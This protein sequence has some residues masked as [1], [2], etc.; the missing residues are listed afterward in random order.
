MTSMLR[1]NGVTGTPVHEDLHQDLVTSIRDS[2]MQNEMLSRAK[3]IVDRAVKNRKVG[4]YSNIPN[5]NCN[6][7]KIFFRG[8]YMDFNSLSI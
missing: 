4:D 2:S 3:Y 1:L 6:N 5:R 8:A 7:N